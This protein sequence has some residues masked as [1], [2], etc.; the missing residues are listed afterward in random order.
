MGMT[1][2]EKPQ[3]IFKTF[4]LLKG[5]GGGQQVL[6]CLKGGGGAQKV[7]DLVLDL[8][9]EQIIHSWCFPVAMDMK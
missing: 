7:L 6:P 5:G 2:F 3:C 8:S 4:H 9:I 1:R